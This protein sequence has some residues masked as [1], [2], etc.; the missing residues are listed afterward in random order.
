MR[1][2]S[3]LATLTALL[4][5]TISCVASSCE[6]TCAARTLGGG[7]HHAASSASKSETQASQSMPGMSDCGMTAKDATLKGSPELLL[8]NSACSHQVCEQPPTIVLNE[9]RLSAQRIATHHAV[10]LAYA[11]FASEPE[12]VT[13]LRTPETPPLRT[14]LL[15]S[16]Q[17]TLRV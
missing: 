17:S 11:F 15:V 12:T 2:R 9:N 10:I 14:T 3:T 7:C 6:A 13:D 1:L 4:M 8:S 16:L 5:L